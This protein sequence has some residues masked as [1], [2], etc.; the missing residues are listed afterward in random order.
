M[1]MN[2][3][4]VIQGIALGSV[5]GFALDSVA[6]DSAFRAENPA[7]APLL[8]LVSASSSVGAQFLSGVHASGAWPV[9]AA[10]IGDEL[11]SM[12]EL[13]RHFR[14]LTGA[15]IVGLLDD[16]TGTLVVDLARGA[17]ARLQWLG[18]HTSQATLSRHHFVHARDAAPGIQ[19]LAR[20]MQSCG[21]PFHIADQSYGD[22]AAR[23]QWRDLRSS[24]VPFVSWPAAIGQL[25]G[26][27]NRAPA[28][29]APATSDTGPVDGRYVSFLIET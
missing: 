28:V 7:T 23:Y 15:R 11:H 22:R 27:F 21:A 2:R 6:R 20:Q 13:E 26:T 8:A 4:T 1:P 5:A 12:L 10:S 19:W 16:A 3:R 25:L 9:Q 24:N 17:G 29:D 14:S 18:Q